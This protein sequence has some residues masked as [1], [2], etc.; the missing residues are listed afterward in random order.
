MNTKN[1]KDIVNDLVKQNKMLRDYGLRKIKKD[2]DAL[3]NYATNVLLREKAEE[4]LK[5]RGISCLK[6]T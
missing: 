2:D 3:I 6:S 5:R 1:K 4:V